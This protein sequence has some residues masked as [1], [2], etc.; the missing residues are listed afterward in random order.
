MI[1]VDRC[2]N[3]LADANNING[4]EREIL[5]YGL[6][7]IYI[8]LS[9]TAILI[10][11]AALMGILKETAALFCVYAAVRSAGFGFHSDNS[12]KCT[13]IGVAEF[14]FATVAA[15]T[16]KPIQIP[17]CVTMF[18][19][20]IVVFAVYAPAETEKRPISAGHKKIFKTAVI[21]IT[22]IMLAL[23]LMAGNSVY[24]N[25]ITFGVCLE[26]LSILPVMKKI[27]K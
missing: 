2:A 20:C 27:L 16:L 5:R 25:L 9:K 4:E 22:A 7:V 10:L 13:I 18:L 12:I 1:F 23:S 3:R 8:N 15:I 11:L 24:R 14:I 6:A 21:A 26:A 17:V 19:L